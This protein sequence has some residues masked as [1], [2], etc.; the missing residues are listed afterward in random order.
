MTLAFVESDMPRAPHMSQS[1]SVAGSGTYTD[2]YPPCTNRAFVSSRVRNM[3]LCQVREVGWGLA[4]STQPNGLEVGVQCEDL[5]AQTHLLHVVPGFEV[6][7]P[8]VCQPFFS[9]YRC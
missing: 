2:K 1:S 7:T 8:S 9:N 6:A 4:Y 5:V 3:A